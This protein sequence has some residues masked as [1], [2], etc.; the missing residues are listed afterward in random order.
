LSEETR[1]L[2][3][4]RRQLRIFGVTVSN[5]EERTAALLEKVAGAQSADE[6]LRAAQD[7]ATLTAELNDVLRNTT[8]LVTSLENR[9]LTALAEV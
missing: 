8:A 6:R 4:T 7:I 3:P 2:D 1:P 5:Y 9:V